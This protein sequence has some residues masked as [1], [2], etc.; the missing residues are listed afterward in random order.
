VCSSDLAYASG[1]WVFH[2]KFGYGTVTGCEGDKL[3]MDFDK[4]GQKHVVARFVNAA[5]AGDNI[6][7]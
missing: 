7:F 4:A 1:D 5:G 3:A 2:Q 6:P